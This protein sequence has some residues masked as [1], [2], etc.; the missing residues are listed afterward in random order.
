MKLYSNGKL[1]DYELGQE[2]ENP[3][4]AEFYVSHEITQLDV[5]IKLAD[6]QTLELVLPYV[7]TVG[8]NYYYS[9]PYNF[10]TSISLA[11]SN[12]STEIIDSEDEPTP[13]PSPTITEIGSFAPPEDEP[14]PTPTLTPKQF[15]NRWYAGRNPLTS[16]NSVTM[17]TQSKYDINAPATISVWFQVG[18]RMSNLTGSL[19][20]GYSEHLYNNSIIYIANERNITV[21]N[22]YIRTAE[23]T[24]D[25]NTWHHIVVTIN[26]SETNDST[27]VYLDGT[28]IYHGINGSTGNLKEDTAHMT[29]PAQYVGGFAIP[30]VIGSSMYHDAGIDEVS[31]FDYEITDVSILRDGTNG[32][33]CDL[34]AL[35]EPPYVWYRFGDESENITS[36]QLLTSVTN[37]GLGTSPT[38]NEPSFYDLT[39]SHSA[40]IYLPTSSSLSESNGQ[41]DDI[42]FTNTKSCL[43]TG[44]SDLYLDSDITLSSE[45][46]ISVW[47]KHLTGNFPYLVD[48]YIF[49]YG[50]AYGNQVYFHDGINTRMVS[51]NNSI[52]QNTWHNVVLTRDDSNNCKLYL[53]GVQKAVTSNFSDTLT[54]RKFGKHNADGLNG[55]LDECAIWTM[56]LSDSD[57]HGI[58]GTTN[59]DAKGTP[60][61]LNA[62]TIKPDHWW[63]C[64]DLD[65][66]ET[67]SKD[68]GTGTA[69]DMQLRSGT[70]FV[71]VVP[72]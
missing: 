71:D 66:S 10:F 69:N 53:D 57:I 26:N 61:D 35:S 9:L 17:R 36:G 37:V 11:G 67:T 50:E 65:D 23:G 46:T 4:R 51:G 55:N 8:G 44:T 43:L 16:V 27:K 40:N 7:T 34:N 24:L 21:G 72:T 38:S 47:F 13:T 42:E 1:V 41:S 22:K 3:I 29:W 2:L 64:G 60:A 48:F 5:I 6:D 58:R 70:S 52:T 12:E 14:T 18:A 19:L 32:K 25:L 49:A 59:A 15:S 20:F 28:R 31:V 30:G 68:R 62:L 54:I 63:R 56:N 45:F 33:P 39:S